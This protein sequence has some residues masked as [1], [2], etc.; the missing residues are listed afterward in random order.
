MR[1]EEKAHPAISV[2]I[3]VGGS[4]ILWALIIWAVVSVLGCSKPAPKAP[5]PV[6]YD[7]CEMVYERVLA[8]SLVQNLDPDHTLSKDE[9]EAGVRLLDEEYRSKGKTASFFAYCGG[10]LNSDQVSCMKTTDSFEGM[11]MCDKLFAAK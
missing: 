11:A 9:Q 1:T 6:S 3:V 2:L 10:H 5:T 4:A 8:I 7:D